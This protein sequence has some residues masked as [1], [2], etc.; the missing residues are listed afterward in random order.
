MRV[1][2]SAAVPDPAASVSRNRPYRLSLAQADQCHVQPWDD[3]ACARFVAR[4]SRFL[5]LG[6]DAT[7]ADDL[8]DRLH[9]RDVQHDDRSTCV[10]CTHYRPGRCGNHHAAQLSTADVGREFATLLQRC[11]GFDSTEAAR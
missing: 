3:T 9:L 8:A 10:E 1:T 5:R 7:D 2:P 4:V 6:I 11:P